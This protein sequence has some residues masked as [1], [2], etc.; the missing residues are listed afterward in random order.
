MVA[1]YFYTAKPIQLAYRGF[2]EFFI[3]FVIGG[4][5]V[6]IGYYLQTQV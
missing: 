3:G 6:L 4:M 5:T 2:G 1:G